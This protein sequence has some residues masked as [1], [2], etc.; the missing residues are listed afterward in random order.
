MNTE[1]RRGDRFVAA[2]L[3]VC[4]AVAAFWE[5][6]AVR[7]S[8]GFQAFQLTA[9]DFEDFRP[10]SAGWMIQSMPVGQSP[11]EPNILAYLVKGQGSAAFV[12][13]AT[14]DELRRAEG[15]RGHGSGFG[16]HGSGFRVHGAGCSIQDEG[17]GY[18]V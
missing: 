14:A 2:V 13:S 12:R 7:S 6:M 1:R 8:R 11:T 10:S 5:I 9:A 3:I 4:V 15:C 18:R 16:V 17:N